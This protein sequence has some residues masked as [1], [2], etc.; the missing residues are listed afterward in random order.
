MNDTNI[1]RLQVRIDLIRA[2][3][4][5]VSYQIERLEE[6]RH[7]LQQEKSHIKEALTKESK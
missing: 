2:E 3:S 1:E 7:E 6:R 5:M 4:R